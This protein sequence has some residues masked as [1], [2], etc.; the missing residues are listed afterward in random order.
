MSFRSEGPAR[1]R[2]FVKVLAVQGIYELTN[3][4]DLPFVA[5]QEDLHVFGSEF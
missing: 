3:A 2:R 5:R 1:R 4:V